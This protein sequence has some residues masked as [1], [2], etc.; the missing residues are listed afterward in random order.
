M[1]RESDYPVELVWEAPPERGNSRLRLYDEALAQIKERPGTW[2]RVRFFDTQSP[3]Y[4]ARKRIVKHYADD[5]WE[6]RVDRVEQD[7]GKW[8]LFVRYRTREQMREAKT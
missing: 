4:A 3:A 7:P 5:H 2:A 8:A 1:G 6:L